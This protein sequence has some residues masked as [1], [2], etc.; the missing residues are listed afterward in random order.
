MDEPVHRFF[1]TPLSEWISLV[2]ELKFDGVALHREV[3]VFRDGFGLEGA[4]LEEAF[5][6]RLEA[7][8][9]AG[10]VPVRTAPSG[11]FREFPPGSGHKL[12][13]YI[14]VPQTQYGYL[15]QEMIEAILTECTV[16][17]R[18]EPREWDLWLATDELMLR[19]NKP[20]AIN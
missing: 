4:S 17:G 12:Q 13:T 15:P 14:W 2:G 8:I 11:N 6:R 5:R 3:E 7:L 20:K 10:A 9:A 16:N 18:L 1:H 19:S